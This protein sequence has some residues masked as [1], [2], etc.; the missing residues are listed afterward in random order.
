MNISEK[1]ELA[2]IAEHI[3]AALKSN[4]VEHVHMTD[5]YTRLHNMA[6]HAHISMDHLYSVMKPQ[7]VQPAAV[8]PAAIKKAAPKKTPAK[9]A[10]RKR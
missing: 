7:A 4:K 5:A 8:R 9:K 1:K 2:Q 3:L 10:A 6:G